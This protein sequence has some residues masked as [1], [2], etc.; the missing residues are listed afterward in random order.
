M[1]INQD[2]DTSRHDKELK[3]R[4]LKTERRLIEVQIEFVKNIPE[5]VAD[6][7]NHKQILQALSSL[8]SVF[9]TQKDLQELLS[10]AVGSLPPALLNR[11][12]SCLSGASTGEEMSIADTLSAL[13]KK[14]ANNLDEFLRL[15]LSKMGPNGYKG[16]LLD[17][18]KL[19]DAQHQDEPPMPLESNRVDRSQISGGGQGLELL[20][21]RYKS[22][23]TET[24]ERLITTSAYH[25]EAFMQAI[26]NDKGLDGLW[27]DQFPAIGEEYARI[28]SGKISRVLS[29]TLYAIF[30]DAC[31]KA[32][33]EIFKACQSPD[34]Q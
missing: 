31:T 6:P 17:G 32:S 15:E 34:L 24:F 8:P 1:S 16:G 13:E 25:F 4:L 12:L 19:D 27:S 28:R 33:F 10:A 21:Q 18:H 9:F 29:D 2:A 23:S 30:T 3:E 26:A 20:K 5:W 14:Y 11:Y 7:D 22:H